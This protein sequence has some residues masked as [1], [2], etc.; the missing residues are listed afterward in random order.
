MDF[1][2]SS[3]VHLTALMSQTTRKMARDFYRAIIRSHFR[4]SLLNKN[5]GAVNSPLSSVTTFNFFFLLDVFERD[6]N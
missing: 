4:T 2:G 3:N 1:E 5:S 6:P